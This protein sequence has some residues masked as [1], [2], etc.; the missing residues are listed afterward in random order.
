MNEYMFK[1]KI[2]VVTGG[3]GGIGKAIANRFEALG[4]KV[5]V[6]DITDMSCKQLRQCNVTIKRKMA[7]S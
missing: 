3:A 4:A 2:A 1:D 5:A 6:I 7:E